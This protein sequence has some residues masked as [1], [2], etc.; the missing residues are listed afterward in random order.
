MGRH[1]VLGLRD[2]RILGCDVLGELELVGMRDNIDLYL[3]HEAEQERRY[4]RWLKS[5]PICDCC[6]ER[7]TD[8]YYYD[9]N[10]TIYC[11]DCLNEEF[12][13]VNE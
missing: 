10:G 5:R 13:F 9:I 2:Y 3:E 11:E 1:Q 12:R 7:I 6:G 4:Q 8:D